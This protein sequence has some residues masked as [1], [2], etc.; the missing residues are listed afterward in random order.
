VK[1]K[2]TKIGVLLVILALATALF[3]LSV[4]AAGEQSE[5]QQT[6][7]ASN[8][9][10]GVST[11]STT[12]KAAFTTASG[13]QFLGVRVS[14]HGNMIS[15][16]SPSGAEAVFAGREGYA[17]CSADGNTVE[18]HD[19]G[20]VEAGFGPPSFVQP[21]AGKFPLTVTRNTTNG[22]FQLKQLWS[23]P[24]SMEKDVTVTMTLKNISSAP[25]TDVLISR[26]GPFDVSV[27]SIDQGARTRDSAWQ[28]DDVSSFDSP[29][30]GLMLTTFARSTPHQTY[31]QPEG[32]WNATRTGC[33]PGTSL[34]TPT[35]AQDLAS[36]VVVD[37]GNLR[38]GESTTVRFQYGR[39]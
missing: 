5:R 29:P 34:T 22:R 27:N 17:V 16:E 35:A 32:D 6:I 13:P 11:Q 31:I 14:N 24:D 18:G 9:D 19:T 37:V 3:A 12:E 33:L 25:I 7:A 15:F 8:K 30:V 21:T 1:D 38:P 28:W 2:R 36:R 10:S 26:S 23:V 20:D 39:M 4:P